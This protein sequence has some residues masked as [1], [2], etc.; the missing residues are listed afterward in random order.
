M[1]G[2]GMSDS[3]FKLK[4]HVEVSSKGGTKHIY[5]VTALLSALLAILIA[6]FFLLR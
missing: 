6:L 3:E 4:A 2:L 5:A 1:E